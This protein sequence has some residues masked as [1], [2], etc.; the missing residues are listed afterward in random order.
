MLAELAGC[1][2]IGLDCA[3][4]VR[5]GLPRF[6]AP[7]HELDRI[8]VGGSCE[9]L[10]Q[11]SDVLVVLFSDRIEAGVESVVRDEIKSLVGKF[12]VVS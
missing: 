7:P 2:L 6:T 8:A 1:K 3:G 9:F 10:H 11:I 5:G 4:S 12:D